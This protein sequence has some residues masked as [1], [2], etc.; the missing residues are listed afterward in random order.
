[1]KTK[2]LPFNFLKDVDQSAALRA[3][4]MKPKFT[5][6]KSDNAWVAQG[7]PVASTVDWEA[8]ANE[9]MDALEAAKG[10]NDAY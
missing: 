4:G 10:G 9:A 8:L 7:K 3:A 1:M 6:S 2:Q 5:Y